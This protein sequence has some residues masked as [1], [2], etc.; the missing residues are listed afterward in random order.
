MQ[1]VV[2]IGC[3]HTCSVC[4]GVQLLV[5]IP[6][7]VSWRPKFDKEMD[8]EMLTDWVQMNFLWM[9]WVYRLPAYAWTLEIVWWWKEEVAVASS[10]CIWNFWAK[11]ELEAGKRL[12]LQTWN[13]CYSSHSGKLTNPHMQLPPRGMC[14]LTFDELR[15]MGVNLLIVSIFV[16]PRQKFAGGQ[17]FWERMMIDWSSCQPNQ[18]YSICFGSIT[19]MYKKL[20]FHR[21]CVLVYSMTLN[22]HNNLRYM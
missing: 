22:G 7:R 19:Y 21:C 13:R 6:T 15:V 12:E 8:L 4:V 14:L 9:H 18:E 3:E 17:P 20:F 2:E 11:R 1:T 16:W 5:G 10:R